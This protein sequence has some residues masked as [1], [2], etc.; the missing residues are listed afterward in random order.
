VAGG[1]GAEGLVVGEPRWHMASAVVAAIVLTILMPDDVQLGPNWLLPL[2]EGVLLVALIASDPG[3]I[4]RPLRALS[5]GLVSVLVLGAL[6][7]LGAGQRRVGGP[8]TP[9]ARAPR[10]R[11]PAAAHS[12]HRV[13][14][15]APSLL[16]LPLSG[17]H[18][19]DRVQSDGRHAA[20]AVGQERHGP[21]SADLT[22]DP[23]SGN[24]ASGERVRVAA[25]RSDGTIG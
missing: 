5:I 22:C 13:G 7:A 25:G 20:G 14:A 4:D 23:W 15:V 17:L 12:L 24:R 19:R 8:C 9:S 2:I 16:R 6:W 1:S 21:A 11:V 3:R 18:Q 10:P